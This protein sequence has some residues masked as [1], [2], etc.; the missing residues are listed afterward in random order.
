VWVERDFVM[1][2]TSSITLIFITCEGDKNPI[3]WGSSEHKIMDRSAGLVDKFFCLFHATKEG[4]GGGGKTKYGVKHNTISI[5]F[6]R[7]RDKMT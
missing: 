7:I 6:T 4:G 1:E 3:Y 5:A 2:I